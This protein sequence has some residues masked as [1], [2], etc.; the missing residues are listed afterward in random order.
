MLTL[1]IATAGG[2]GAILRYL[3]DALLAAHRPWGIFC[4][5]AIGS[6]FLGTLLSFALVPDPAWIAVLGVGFCGGFTTFSTAS[7][8]A[9][10][11]YLTRTELSKVQRVFGA[12]TYSLA[13]F[14]VCVACACIG[15]LLVS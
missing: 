1:G 12:A 13:M 9:V 15:N 4:I 5:N 8:D 11:I 14:L 3:I 6:F 10:R 7:M 2:I